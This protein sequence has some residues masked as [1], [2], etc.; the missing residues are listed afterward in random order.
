MSTIIK[1]IWNNIQFRKIMN[2]YKRESPKP[3]YIEK[4]DYY[5]NNTYMIGCD[6]GNPEI[7]KEWDSDLDAYYYF[8]ECKA[9]NYFWEGPMW[10]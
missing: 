8:Y 3:S 7:T 2:E 6:C 5:S 10:C 1:K 4:D 9:C